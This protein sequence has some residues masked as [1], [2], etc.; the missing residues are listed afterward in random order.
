MILLYK[1]VELIKKISAET[2]EN[3]KPVAVIY[4]T[5]IGIKPL[6]IQIEQK[7]LLIEKD[8]V[9]T[10]NV[11]DFE[12]GATVKVGEKVILLREQKGQKYVVLNRVR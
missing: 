8:L 10:D 7:L 6:K 1:L 12:T 2:I 11:Q 4:G 5:V 3:N 9:L